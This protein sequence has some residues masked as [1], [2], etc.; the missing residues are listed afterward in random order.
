MRYLSAASPSSVR[1]SAS[2]ESFLLK[3]FDTATL[4]GEMH[5]VDFIGKPP[6]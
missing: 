4:Q 3:G 6:T 1:W 2:Q 5:L